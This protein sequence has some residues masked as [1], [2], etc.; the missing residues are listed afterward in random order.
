MFL[1]DSSLLEIVVEARLPEIQIY[2]LIISANSSSNSLL[3]TNSLY[4]KT[5][6]ETDLLRIISLTC[7]HINGRPPYST[8]NNWF[9]KLERTCN[10]TK[11]FYFR[12]ILDEGKSEMNI[13]LSPFVCYH[14]SCCWIIKF[15]NKLWFLSFFSLAYIFN[16][17]L[18]SFGCICCQIT[19]NSE[20]K[21][22]VSSHIRA[23]T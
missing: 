16:V 18:F 7:E 3:W 20:K 8:R 4:I 14:C 1:S 19:K 9:I 15:W 6:S 2:P 11:F 10:V 23:M 5:C 13:F 21:L 17:K 12:P 22:P